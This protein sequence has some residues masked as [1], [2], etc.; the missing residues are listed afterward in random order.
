MKGCTAMFRQFGGVQLWDISV[1]T[2]IW[3]RSPTLFLL[4]SNFSLSRRK[5]TFSQA[6]G[7]Q[8]KQKENI[9][10]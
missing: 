3:E 2:A 6:G 9:V 4:T 5:C 7:N 10:A 1:E 8:T